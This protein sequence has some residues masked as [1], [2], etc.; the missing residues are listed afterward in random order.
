MQHTKNGLKRTKRKI[1]NEMNRSN[2]N[3]LRNEKELGRNTRKQE[4]GK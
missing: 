1:Q 3:G 2:Y 4:I